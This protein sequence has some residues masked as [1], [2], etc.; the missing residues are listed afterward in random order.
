MP[1]ACLLEQT[2]HNIEHVP[3]GRDGNSSVSSARHQRAIVPHLRPTSPSKFLHRGLACKQALRHSHAAD[4]EASRLEKPLIERNL[5][6]ECA[7]D[8]Q[9]LPQASLATLRE[10]RKRIVRGTTRTYRPS[11]QSDACAQG[12]MDPRSISISNILLSVR[13]RSTFEQTSASPSMISSQHEQR[14]TAESMRVLSVHWKIP[15]TEYHAN[16]ISS[17]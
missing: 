14:P 3:T 12:R 11:T 4:S 5:S 17:L 7:R 10:I 13:G 2:Q 9:S 6:R 16:S 1:I 15:P 8:E